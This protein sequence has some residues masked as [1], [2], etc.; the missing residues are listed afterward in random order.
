[1][2]IVSTILL[3]ALSGSAFSQKASPF[4]KF[5]KVTIADLQKNIYNIDSNANA[6]VLSDI[7]E[8][9]VEGNSKGWFS[10]SFKHHKVVHILNKNG[11]HEADVEVPLY[12]DNS[13]EEKLESVRGITY[14]FENGKIVETK[15]DKAG[16]FKEKIDKNRIR[17]KFTMPNVKEGCIIEYEYT[18]TSDF[19]W[20]LDPW[21]FQG[22]SPELWSE[23][24]LTVPEF[25]SY[26]FLSRGFHP[27]S[28][29]EKANRQTNFSV[30]DTRTSGS[31]ER[32][33]FTA[34]VTDYRWVALNVPE[35]KEE[36]FT[37]SI[38]NHLS[39][40]EFQLVTQNYPL[41]PRNF[42]T[43]WPL[44]M[45]G[46]LESENFGSSLK[47]NNNWLSDNIKP[48]FASATSD[49]EKARK[50]FT[51]VR[52]N[53]SCT[54]NGG[55][56]LDQSLKEIMKAKKGSVSEVN[57]L[58]TAMFRYAGLKAMPV[59]LSTTSHGYPMDMYPMISSFN[60]VVVQL[61]LNGQLYYLDASH[62]RLGFNKLLSTCYNG[63]ARIVDAYATSINF[64]ADSL[65]EKKVTSL[66]I[67]NDKEGKWIGS[68]NQTPGYY[69]SYQIRDKVKE[70]GEENFFKEIQKA[71]P[72]EIAITEPKVDSLTRY[73]EPVSLHYGME[74]KPWT[75]DILYINP[76]F[77]EAYKKN[78]FTS[79]ERVYPV[80]MPYTMDE[81]LTATIE[82]PAGYVVD[83]LPKQMLAKYDESG[84]SF[85]EYRITQS[86]DRI[87]F[88][89]RIKINRALFMPDEYEVLREFFNIIVSKQSEQI[90]FK[91]KK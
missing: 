85:F 70:E 73:D 77:G 17:K 44:I 16:I 51:Y 9:A 60:Y 10:I 62:P 13:A 45:K 58:L 68:F 18:V 89:S 72:I 90:V 75:E 4:Y 78:P 27:I 3:M 26:A 38:K 52:D 84:A 55:I 53:F 79:A 56:G 47:S 15:L 20:N 32:F 25:F 61:D 87:S 7:G 65:S 42:R 63:P 40:M 33:S 34:Q 22:A 91:K 29:N 59:L 35:L 39:R 67:A 41:P 36:S 11:Y 6:V 80:E 31:S 83:E 12:V 28:I 24:T 43:S 69:E 64:S 81:T 66:F 21:L 49:I 46:L 8:A 57:I 2:R 54:G 48:V 5:G 14:N 23:F 71:Y 88:R 82:I 19:I 86:V 50:L 37:S 1:M 76:M 30:M 74:M